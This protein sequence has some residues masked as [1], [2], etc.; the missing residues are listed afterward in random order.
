MTIAVTALQIRG[1][2]LCSLWAVQSTALA[3]HAGEEG[4]IYSQLVLPL[5]EFVS[6]SSR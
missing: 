4:G 2:C 3:L 1:L 5:Q 6:T